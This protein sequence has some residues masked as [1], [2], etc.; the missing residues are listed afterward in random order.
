[1]NHQVNSRDERAET[2]SPAVARATMHRLRLLDESEALVARLYRHRA[3]GSARWGSALSGALNRR[4]R[5]MRSACD[6]VG[7]AF[8]A[9]SP[10]REGVTA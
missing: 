2:L 3:R 7:A 5:R 9:M 6:A 4:Q 1:M 10:Q 8:L